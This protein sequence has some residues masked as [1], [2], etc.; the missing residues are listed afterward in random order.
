LFTTTERL[1]VQHM[2]IKPKNWS[3][4][5]H[6]KD[7]SPKWIKLHRGLLDD[8][9]F[10]CLP[11]AS[12][13]LAPML[14]LLASED[15]DGQV[16][17]NWE[18][19]AF[20][21]RCGAE[22]IEQAVKSLIEGGFFTVVQN[23]SKPLAELERNASLEKSKSREEREE[24]KNGA[25]APDGY[26]TEFESAWSKYPKRA[27]GNP[28]SKAWK[29]WKARIADGESVSVM[30]AGVDRYATFARSTG[31]VGT[32]FVQQAATF[33]GPDRH[34]LEDWIPPTTESFDHLDYQEGIGDDGRLQ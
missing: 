11:L 16:C 5:Q 18:K 15:D 25:N 29:A 2:V 27:G 14:W 21:L 24:S 12:R 19:L 9:E 4:F 20:R 28:K 1:T 3:D 31:K 8:F 13:A 30:T 10:H 17:C 23:A 33:F 22:E 26:S 32:E 7:R 34:Y 6:Y